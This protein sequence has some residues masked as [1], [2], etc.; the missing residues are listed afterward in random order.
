MATC[1]NP[2]VFEGVILDMR[3]GVNHQNLMENGETV[4]T[5]LVWALLLQKPM[6]FQLC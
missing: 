3:Q 5:E 6:V 4:T 2:L 1:I